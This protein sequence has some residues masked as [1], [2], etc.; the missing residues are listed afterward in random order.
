[1]P[2]K[3]KPVFQP[4]IIYPGIISSH[5]VPDILMLVLRSNEPISHLSATQAPISAIS[6]RQLCLSKQL[7][8]SIYPTLPSPRSLPLK[9]I[10]FE[11]EC[12]VLPCQTCRRRYAVTISHSSPF[13]KLVGH[14][15][16]KTQCTIFFPF[17]IF[18]FIFS[19]KQTRV[20]SARNSKVNSY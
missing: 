2:A 9:K 12:L 13:P 4:D 20:S 14:C 18:A 19:K 11:L 15:R 3:L 8:S 10:Y 17:R 1:M 6:N 16:D 5:D 7:T